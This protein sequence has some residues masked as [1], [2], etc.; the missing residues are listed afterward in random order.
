MDE[1]SAA[2]LRDLPPSAKLVYWVLTVE[3]KLTQ[4]G[5]VEESL[6]SARTVRYA[7]DRLKSAGLVRETVYIPD[8][9]KSVYLVTDEAN[10]ASD[11][12]AATALD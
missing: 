3:G 11:P 5:I 6:L 10:D 12:R 9:R 1:R 2:R 8:A 7:L 4:G